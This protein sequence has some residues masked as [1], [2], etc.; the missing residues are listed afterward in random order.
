MIN[1]LIIA[2]FK[3]RFLTFLTFI[4]L[5]VVGVVM[6]LRTPVDALP[7]LS[8]NQVIVMTEWMGQSP[9][10][11]E[12]Q[13]TYPLTVAF[14]GLPNVKA[15]R[16]GSQ[17]GLSMVTIIFEDSVPY[18]FARDRVSERLRLVTMDLPPG[19][20]PV[21]GPD[22]TGLGHIFMYTLTSDQRS[23]TE[24][25]TLHDFTVRYALQSV[26]G[27]AEIAPVGG[28]L[29]TYQILLDPVKLSQYGVPLMDIAKRVS[30]SNAN[31][32]GKVVTTGERE[33]AIQGYGF[34]KTTESLKQLVIGERRDGLP[35]TL[36]DVAAV[37]ESGA[38]RRSI[39]ADD[40]GEKVGAIVVMRFG[41][42]PLA[43]ID[44]VKARI[45]DVQKS[46]PKDVKI[47]PFYDRTDLIRG[48]IHT[49]TRVITEEMVVTAIILAIFL[50]HFGATIITN[51]GLL[52]GVI[53]TFIF[54]YVF[55]IPSNIMSLGGVAISIG[56]MVDA[57]IV[58]TENMYRKFLTHKPKT[59][60][61][62]LHLAQESTL[63]VGRPIMFAILITI[64]SFIPIFSL[65]GMEGKLFTPLAW[66]H[67]FGLAGAL[68]AA[69][70]LVP[71]LGLYLLRGKLHEDH[72]IKFVAWLQQKYAPILRGALHNR[73]RQM[74]MV[75][76]GALI[77]FA[78]AFRIGSEFMPPL[79]EGTLLYMPITAA[80]VSEQRAQEMLIASNKIIA[81][82]PEVEKV[83]G[84]AGRASTATDPSPLA[85]FES[86]ITLKPK[87]EWRPDMTKEKLIRE[88]NKKLKIEGLW[89]G[90]TQ[91]IIGRID[92][93]STGVRTQVGV[94]VYGDDPIKL[95]K[96]AI[97]AEKIL[98]TVPGASNVVA[99]R[100]N[101]LKYLNITLNEGKLARY[102][103]M[104]SDALSLISTGIGGETVATTVDGR[105]RYAIEV[106]LAV[107]SR[108]NLEDIRSLLVHTA[109]GVHIPLASVADIS[110]EDGPAMIQS[111]DG[112]I[113]SIVQMG[114]VGRDMGSFVEE[115]KE[116]LASKLQLPSGYSVQWTGQYEH[117]MRAKATL[118]W[119]VPVVLLV[120]FVLLYLAYHDFGLV[121]IVM[122]TIPLSLSGGLIGLLIAGYN[123]SVA[124]WVGFITLFGTAVSMSVVKVV[125]LENAYRVRFGIPVIEGEGHEFGGPVK[126]KVVTKA[127]IEEAI[128]EG[129][130]L[131]LRPILMT[132]L[133][134]IIGLVPMLTSHG[135]GAEV[136]KPLAVVL[137]GGLIS[138]VTMTLTLVPVLFAY[139]RERK[140]GTFGTKSL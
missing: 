103:V 65:S 91:P 25:R 66:T 61:E 84:K 90:F 47:V 139:L 21:L 75:A 72:E 101:G 34:F 52:V 50:F 81:S 124:V 130:T 79:D 97:E 137:I 35:L 140:I 27:V 116:T 53:L 100:N 83:V 115:A 121:V 8:E 63:E 136:T 89:N 18:Y 132:T 120:I 105:K 128:V 119:V 16:G 59:F 94:K 127:G 20:T 26:P 62:R 106:R 76:I 125:Y 92:M 40:K 15:V 131:R 28:Y 56:V 55:K 134:T 69:L 43:V 22:A 14:Q 129:A 85:M 29:K 112:L 138:A 7:D 104:K 111:E 32:S 74:I 93:I 123:F 86:V 13:I 12:D 41:E 73:K 78:L 38:Y 24:L 88:M 102:G 36:S 51:I 4:V 48:A 2:A 96:L 113:T 77:T 87:E 46:L 126:P 64:V 1:Y 122:L 57:G 109:S 17:V 108:Q 95:E 10:N 5:V 80:D 44:A 19:V 110:F 114:I 23:L 54:M 42:N 30:E 39:L 117:Q 45:A 9:R 60:E 68:I 31:V 107:A 135:T 6:I 133:V 58:I 82:F 70:F 99:V 3:N 71:L 118:T 98:E 11:V 49:M 37:R 33:I 67:L